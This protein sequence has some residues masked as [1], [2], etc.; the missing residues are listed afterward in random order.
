MSTNPQ[1]IPSENVEILVSP[2]SLDQKSEESDTAQKSPSRENSASSNESPKPI[3]AK[4]RTNS[5]DSDRENAV[6]E[7]HV[8]SIVEPK[9]MAETIFDPK[10][11]EPMFAVKKDGK[12]TIEWSLSR[13][14]SKYQKVDIEIFPPADPNQLIPRGVV[15]LPAKVAPYRSQ[16]ELI[17][18]IEGFI[19]RYADLPPFWEKLLAHYVLMSWVFDKFSAVPYLRFLGEPQT[20]KTRALQIVRALCHK[21]ILVGGATSTAPIFRLI[22]VY[23]GT[24]VIDEADYKDSEEWSEIIKIL[25]NGYM[26]GIPVLRSDGKDYEPR[27]FEVYGPKVLSTRKRFSDVALESRCITLETKEGVVRADVPLQLPP[28]FVEEA[29]KL[30]DK[31]LQWRFDRYDQIESDEDKLR[32]L[33]PRLAQIGT[34][35]FAVSTDEDFRNNLVQFL[36]DHGKKE[37]SQRPQAAVI[38]AIHQLTDENSSQARGKSGGRLLIKEIT[39]RANQVASSWGQGESQL[40]PRATGGLIRSVGFTSRRTGKGYESRRRPTAFACPAGEV[41]FNR[42]MMNFVN[43]MK[44]FFGCENNTEEQF[45]SASDI[46]NLRGLLFLRKGSTFTHI[47]NVHPEHIHDVHHLHIPTR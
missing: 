7:I 2:R 17:A 47:S 18:E 23:R 44:P 14:R 22:D 46:R 11:G 25:N 5:E 16:E 36:S 20:G 24:F 37:K 10:F 27:A 43:V 9:L 29:Q 33:E 41:R 12:I 32:H 45:R 26:R 40:N 1:P 31:L 6:K 19:H 4:K 15:L 30:R 38:E 42:R 34:P 39:E 35:L 13:K 21:S 28:K 8:A 3:K